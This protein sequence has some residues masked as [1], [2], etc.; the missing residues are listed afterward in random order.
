MG[1]EPD[2][3]TVEEAAAVLRISRT[4][5]YR[6][7]R[8]WPETGGAEGIP[9]E[10]VG[11]LLRVPRAKLE[12]LAGGPIHLSDGLLRKRLRTSGTG[13]KA[14]RQDAGV[15]SPEAGG[16]EAGEACRADRPPADPV[17]GRRPQLG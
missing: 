17:L 2:F 5:A 13:T 9:C 4:V 16:P 6:L 8:L 11:H 14:K 7:C 15:R 10:R 3:L 1:P 12:E